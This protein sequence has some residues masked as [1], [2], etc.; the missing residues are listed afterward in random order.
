MIFNYSESTFAVVL[1]TVR[2]C[3][4][5]YD[6]GIFFCYVKKTH[7][8]LRTFNKKKVSGRIEEIWEWLFLGNMIR[9]IGE[10]I[11]TVRELL[12]DVNNFAR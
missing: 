2:D 1:S 7:K 11:V 10:M 3:A 9:A 5:Q 4:I 6:E 8:I 12:D